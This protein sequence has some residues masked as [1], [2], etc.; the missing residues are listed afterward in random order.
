[1]L[2]HT[3]HT[4]SLQLRAATRAELLQALHATMCAA[5]SRLGR[6]DLHSTAGAAGA[7]AE[8]ALTVLGVHAPGVV[9]FLFLN[10][11]VALSQPCALRRKLPANL[12]I[13]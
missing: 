7:A 5:R 3:L 12:P 10:R 1:M 4:L 8:S 9:S 13:R 2:D 6:L 11:H